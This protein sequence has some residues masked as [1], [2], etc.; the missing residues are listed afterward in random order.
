MYL[1]EKKTNWE[2]MLDASFGKE[3]RK[4]TAKGASAPNYPKLVSLRRNVCSC[5]ANLH[6]LYVIAQIP[7][8]ETETEFL[9]TGRER[10]LIYVGEVYLKPKSFRLCFHKAGRW[11]RRGLWGYETIWS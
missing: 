2:R 5:L 4:I 11:P 6:P 8:K 1:L 9:K 3:R 10:K 7:G